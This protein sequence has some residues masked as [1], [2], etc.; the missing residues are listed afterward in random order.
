[1][2]LMIGKGKIGAPARRWMWTAFVP[3]A[4]VSL[5]L[6][7]IIESEFTDEPWSAGFYTLM[8]SVIAVHELVGPVLM[9]LGIARSD[10]RTL[11]DGVRA[12]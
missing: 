8:L 4:G 9:K 6:A 3:Q 7:A 10:G 12:G 5:A 1:M 2:G 11:Q